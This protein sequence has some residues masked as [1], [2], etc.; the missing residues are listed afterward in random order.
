MIG[1]ELDDRLAEGG[2]KFA[3]SLYRAK[4]LGV[5]ADC[6]ASGELMRGACWMA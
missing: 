3:T 2:F 1:G 6:K 5:P 4:V